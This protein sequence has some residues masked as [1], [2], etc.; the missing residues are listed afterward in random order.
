[1]KNQ[2]TDP[3]MSRLPADLTDD[4]LYEVSGGMEIPGTVCSHCGGTDFKVFH[5]YPKTDKECFKVF[6]KN[7]Y[8]T[9]DAD[10]NLLKELFDTE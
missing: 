9:V 3:M 2:C 8:L 5:L 7:C 6:C 1:M 4:E 10:K